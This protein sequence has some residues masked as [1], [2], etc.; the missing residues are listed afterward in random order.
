MVMV[1]DPQELVLFIFEV[2]LKVRRLTYEQLV[3]K[4]RIRRGLTRSL[5]RLKAQGKIHYIL[6]SN[7]QIHGD[8]VVSLCTVV[9]MGYDLKLVILDPDAA[10]LLESKPT[11]QIL[12]LD[13]LEESPYL[14][15]KVFRSGAS[16]NPLYSLKTWLY[17]NVSSTAVGES[18]P[19]IE[20]ALNICYRKYVA[21]HTKV[22]A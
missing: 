2:E 16:Q 21:R 18:W 7:G 12:V 14:E 17:N 8:T 11:W 22:G 4:T 3:Q 1:I 15:P 13:F 5:E 9:D 19:K 10:E 6:D 20:E